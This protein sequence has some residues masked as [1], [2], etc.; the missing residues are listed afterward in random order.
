M[1][2]N[3]MLVIAERAKAKVE[4]LLHIY[5]LR[6]LQFSDNFIDRRATDKRAKLHA[7]TALSDEARRHAPA[8]GRCSPRTKEFHARAGWRPTATSATADGEDAGQ[9][10][11]DIIT[12]ASGEAR[13]VPRAHQQGLQRV[14]RGACSSSSKLR[15]AGHRPVDDAAPEA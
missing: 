5:R 10:S 8:E 12:L 2:L 13:A 11:G 4:S 15:G 3:S 9:E 14:R 6:A 1:N 7:A